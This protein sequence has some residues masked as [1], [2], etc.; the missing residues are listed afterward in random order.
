LTPKVCPSKKTWPDSIRLT[1]PKSCEKLA[2]RR[3]PRRADE[4]IE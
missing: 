3:A 4:V 2:Q 1:G